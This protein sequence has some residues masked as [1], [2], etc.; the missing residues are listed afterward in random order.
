MMKQKDFYGLSY[1][2][3]AAQWVEALPL[4]N[5][6]LGGMIYGSL[7]DEIIQINEETVWAGYPRC[8]DN[9]EAYNRLSKIRESIFQGDYDGAMEHAGQMLGQPEQLE[10][11][12]PVCDVLMRF[13]QH[14]IYREYWRGAPFANGVYYPR[15]STSQR[16]SI[17]S[18]TSG[19]QTGWS[20]PRKLQPRRFAARPPIS[21]PTAIRANTANK[22]V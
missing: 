4:G 13:H 14:G 15:G 22:P 21:W 19:R 8:R 18:G 9:P 12:Q 6:K 7:H 17:P 3:P 5:A 2:T 20:A 16:R 11:Y 10:S 1:S